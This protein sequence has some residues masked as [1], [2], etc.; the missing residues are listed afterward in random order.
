MLAG[1]PRGNA[2]RGLGEGSL[3]EKTAIDIGSAKARAGEAALQACRGAVQMHGAM[4][5]TEEGGVGVYLRAAM[6][7]S[8]WLGNVPAHRRR[9]LAAA[10]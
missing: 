10:S 1:G 3:A 6:Q 9:F 4:G 7:F 2:K 5:F 8:T